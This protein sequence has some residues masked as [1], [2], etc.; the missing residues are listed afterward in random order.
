MST[1]G[2]TLMPVIISSSEEAEAAM[3][4]SCRLE[5]KWMGEKARR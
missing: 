2:V 1:S 3:G 5:Q 4:I